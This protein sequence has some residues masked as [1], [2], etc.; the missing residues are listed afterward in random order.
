MDRLKYTKALSLVICAAGALV[1]AG[2]ALNVTFL[3]SVSADFVSMKFTT[4]LCFFLSGVTLYMITLSMEERKDVSHAVLPATV[5][6]VL[7]IMTTLLTSALFGID[8]GVEEMFMR[9]GP[10]PALTPVPGRPSVVTMI[11]FILIA[12]CGIAAMFSRNRL[13]AVLFYTG[14]FIML[15]GAVAIAGY[16]FG[17]PALYYYSPPATAMALHTALLFALCGW[18]LVEFSRVEV[19]R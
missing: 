15:T 13:R 5:L 3:K 16:V 14:G 19:E 9:G 4:A 18:V 7:L 8:S 1:M 10:H 12:A 17:L 6:I 2:W 11:D